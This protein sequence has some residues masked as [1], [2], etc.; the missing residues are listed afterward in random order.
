MTTTRRVPL[1]TKIYFIC[2]FFSFAPFFVDRLFLVD[3]RYNTYS[4]K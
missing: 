1:T 2:N 4:A 3:T